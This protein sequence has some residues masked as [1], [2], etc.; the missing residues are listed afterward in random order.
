MNTSDEG[1]RS[2]RFVIIDSQVNVPS[3]VNV[4][5]TDTKALEKSS[6]ES[7][8]QTQ[9]A[10]KSTRSES[11]FS[12]KELS[13]RRIIHPGMKNP[14]VLNAFR[15]LR[16]SLTKKMTGPNAVI[17]VSAVN[18]GGGGSFTATNLATAFTFEKDREALLIDCNMMDPTLHKSLDVDHEAGLCDYLTGKTDNVE[19]LIYPTGIPRLSM[20]PCGSENIDRDGL[21]E[22]FTDDRM[23]QFIEQVRG[24]QDNRT[25]LLDAAPILDSA[26]TRVLAE[27]SEL[28]VVAL[29]YKG[30]TSNRVA[31]TIEEFGG[32]ENISGFV[33]VN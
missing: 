17:L 33:M 14:E 10:V 16:L 4:G 20:V 29:P 15:S 25:V 1:K 30:A 22:L 32:R 21:V 19:Q 6:V 31:K 2:P 24:L 12:R 5:I 9:N 11:G 26:D 23:R 8:T 3:N 7:D 28:V 13:R 27:L 18:S